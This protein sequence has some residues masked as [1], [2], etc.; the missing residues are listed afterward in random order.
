MKRVEISGS[1]ERVIERFVASGRCESAKQ[2]VDISLRLLDK[3]E[4]LRDTL[5]QDIVAG[6]EEVFG[7]QTTPLDMEGIIQEAEEKHASDTPST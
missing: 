6:M 1:G 4:A 3:Q 7:G 2:V 5:R